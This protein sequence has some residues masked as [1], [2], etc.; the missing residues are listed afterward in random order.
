M[1]PQEAGRLGGLARA[2]TT[3]K[4]RMAEIAQMGGLTARANDRLRKAQKGGISSSDAPDEGLEPSLV[5]V[6]LLGS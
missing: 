3:S 1:T 4:E 2:Q 5:P 6:D